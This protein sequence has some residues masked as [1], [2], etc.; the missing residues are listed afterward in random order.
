LGQGLAGMFG[1]SADTAS[2][3]LAGLCLGLALLLMA[4]LN[5]KLAD[6]ERYIPR[7]TR[8]L[9]PLSSDGEPGVGEICEA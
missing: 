4:Y 3:V 9:P 7:I 5:R 2:I 6:Q 8:I 1:W